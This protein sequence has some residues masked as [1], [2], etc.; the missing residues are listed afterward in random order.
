MAVEG[1]G[2]AEG[3]VVALLD[4]RSGAGSDRSPRKGSD[5]ACDP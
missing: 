2:H 4:D 3:E 1:V 5:H